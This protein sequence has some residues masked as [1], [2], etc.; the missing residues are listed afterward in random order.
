[1]KINQKSAIQVAE[2]LARCAPLAEPSP[3]RD[4]LWLVVRALVCTTG[5][6]TVVPLGSNRQVVVT[7]DYAC[8]ELVGAMQWLTNHEDDARQMKPAKLYRKM[9]GAATKGVYGSAR[10][11][12]ADDLHG[13]THVP[14]GRSVRFE[15]FAIDEQVA[16]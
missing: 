14:A 6:R 8:Q 12:Q 3:E 4:T 2:A 10:A 7:G 13:L 15:E 11:A 1:M 5:R 16:S 9:R